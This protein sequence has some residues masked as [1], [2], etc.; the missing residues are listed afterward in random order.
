MPTVTDLTGRK[1]SWDARAP[2][3]GRSS[4]ARRMRRKMQNGQLAEEPTGQRQ[5][6][7]RQVELVG[8]YKRGEVYWYKIHGQVSRGFSKAPQRQVGSTDEAATPYVFGLRAS[9]DSGKEEARRY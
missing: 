1:S 3:F 4:G 6:K 5:A 9:R 8:I 7:R 2:R